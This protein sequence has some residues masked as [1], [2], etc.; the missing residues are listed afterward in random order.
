MNRPEDELPL[1]PNELCQE[2]ESLMV[3]D[4]ELHPLLKNFISPVE[5][6]RAAEAITEFVDSL[7]REYPIERSWA[8]SLFHDLVALSFLPP[9]EGGAI[10]FIAKSK[11]EISNSQDIL[12]PFKNKDSAKEKLEAA[13]TIIDMVLVC[14]V[15]QLNVTFQRIRSGCD[16][17]FDHVFINLL[18]G[19][20]PIMKAFSDWYDLVKGEDWQ[21]FGQLSYAIGEMNERYLVSPESGIRLI[22]RLIA[23]VLFGYD[24]CLRIAKSTPEKT[25]GVEAFFEISNPQQFGR[26]SVESGLETPSAPPQVFNSGI[27]GPVTL[28]ELPDTMAFFIQ[29][30]FHHLSLRELWSE[31][32]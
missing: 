5:I 21:Q 18:A 14:L 12:G 13:A 26:A 8:L 32:E 24:T 20:K 28:K 16:D 11:T 7:A 10:T 31:L 15:G 1:S 4:I 6:K 22:R 17:V 2:V 9:E 23:N 3:T 29:L 19:K 27:P 25:V 30:V